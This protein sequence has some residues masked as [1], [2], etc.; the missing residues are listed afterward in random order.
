M[1]KFMLTMDCNEIIKTFNYNVEYIIQNQIDE[2]VLR[3]ALQREN[4]YL[5]EDDEIFVQYPD[6]EGYYCSNY[7]R[8][9]STKGKE[10]KFIKQLP[11]TKVYKG[12][13]LS[14]PNKEQ[15]T[16]TTGRMVADIFCLNFYRDKERDF[17]DV[18]HIDHNPENNCWKNLALLPESLHTGTVHKC[19]KKYGVKDVFEICVSPTIDG[20]LYPENKNA[21]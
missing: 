14:D 5:V 6:W 4:Q 3:W 1:R 9:I 11:L 20:N 18:H 17:L 7:G 10:P 13:T 12:Y 19:D 16:L 15:L 2:D 21:E 8:L